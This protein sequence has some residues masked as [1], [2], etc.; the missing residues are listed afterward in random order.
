M[1]EATPNTGSEQVNSASADTGAP[2]SAD[3]GQQNT[4]FSEQ[5]R[6]ALGVLDGGDGIDLS[7][8]SEQRQ[9]ALGAAT[10]AGVR[11]RDER[12]RF[13]EGKGSEVA[14]QAPAASSPSSPATPPSAGAPA[15]KTFEF[16]GEKFVDQAAAEQSFKSLRGQFKPMIERVQSAEA[17]RD[18]AST[19]A[20]SW[21]AEAERLTKELE[22]LRGGAPATGGKQ[23]G[24]GGA[25]TGA[26]TAAGEGELD[27][28]ERFLYEHA[29][30][31]IAD[32]KIG[33]GGFQ[34]ALREIQDKRVEARVAAV[35]K[36]FE[37]KLEAG[38]A[39]SRESSELQTLKTTADTLIADMSTHV[40]PAGHARAGQV[41]YPEL[42]DSDKIAAIAS[43]WKAEGREPA[44]LFT[45]Q[46]LRAAI[47]LYRFTYGEP[48][49][50]PAPTATPT[51]VV[52]PQPSSADTAAAMAGHAAP[53]VRPTGA[54]ASRAD[55]VRRGMRD[56]DV[57]QNVFGVAP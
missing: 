54:P 47:A 23:P 43:H 38:L 25:P 41:A 12:G 53:A 55:A 36:R 28:D 27:A 24:T 48:A 49:A 29:A 26:V 37:E 45:H 52:P 21:K 11:A 16:G 9:A 40:W 15:A 39:P 14:P 8:T 7:Q 50:A 18:R 42:G 44:D 51:P 17:E 33:M 3:A 19:S 20:H 31:L 22:A 1:T 30:E 4:G 34:L 56:A 2:A 5:D 13:V 35:E 10:A 57:G 32:P 46:G 6:G